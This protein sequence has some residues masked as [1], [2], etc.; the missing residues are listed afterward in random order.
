MSGKPQNWPL[1]IE[2][3]K[4]AHPDALF[5]D[6]DLGG[7]TFTFAFKRPG[8]VH[9]NL[10]TGGAA[11]KL[12]KNMSNMIA[13]CLIAPEHELAQP[14]FNYYPAAVLSLGGQLLE[15][16]GLVDGEVRRP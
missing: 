9:V 12:G 13:D 15:A 4:E 8:R 16:V 10:A 1:E 11:K 14:F 5:V 2:A 7:E 6:L 3:I